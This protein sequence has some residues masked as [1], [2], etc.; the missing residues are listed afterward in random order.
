MWLPKLKSQMLFIVNA[1]VKHELETC[2][3]HWKKTQN[4]ER[5]TTI[6]NLHDNKC[7]NLMADP[8]LEKITA[9][10]QKKNHQGHLP[11]EVSLRN[12]THWSNEINL[13]GAGRS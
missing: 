2:K 4:R 13:H 9:S 5:S 7:R 1:Q 10:L 12:K 3:C 6:P 11:M 8:Q